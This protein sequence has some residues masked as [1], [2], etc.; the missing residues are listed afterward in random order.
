M[1]I[2]TNIK[3]FLKGSLI[4]LLTIIAAVLCIL[5]VGFFGDYFISHPFDAPVDLTNSLSIDIIGAVIPAVAGLASA[6]LYLGYFKFPKMSLLPSLIA[7]VF[8]AFLLFRLTDI[9]VEGS[10]LLFSLLSSEVMVA[11]NTL[12]K[13]ITQSKQKYASF[14]LASVVCVPLSLLSVDLFYA[15]S[16]TNAIIGG[17]GLSDAVLISTLYAPL[18][19]TLVYSILVYAMQIVWLI[20][21]G[22]SISAKNT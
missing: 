6:A 7:S 11:F 18:A 14:L 10:P 19:A 4:A 1:P 21:Y 13:P 3:K 5:L 15:S 22:L 8:L 16:F 20:K 2:D 9:G 12:P 17:N